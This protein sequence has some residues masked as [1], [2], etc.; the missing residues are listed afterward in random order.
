MFIGLA[1]EDGLVGLMSVY[2]KQLLIHSLM[3]TISGFCLLGMPMLL[4]GMGG[5]FLLVVPDKQLVV[6]YLAWPY[7][8]DAFFDQ[9]TELM[10]LII[11]SCN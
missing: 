1:I 7:S 11:E 6:V 8:L 2:G 3:A 9:R 5:Q 4:W 10:N